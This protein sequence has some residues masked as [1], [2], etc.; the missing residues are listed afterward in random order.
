MK[1]KE[2]E[3]FLKE[4]SNRHLL[5]MVVKEQNL[6]LIKSGALVSVYY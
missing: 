6:P 4:K 2:I 3:K 1:I 5:K